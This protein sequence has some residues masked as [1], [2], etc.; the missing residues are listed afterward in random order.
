[1]EQKDFTCVFGADVLLPNTD[2]YTSFAV[3]ACDQFTSNGEYWQE[4]ADLTKGKLTALDMILPEYYLNGDYSSRIQ[5]IN[6]NIKNYVNQAVVLKNSMVLTVRET[7]SGIKRTGLVLAVDLE[8]YNFI[9]GEKPLIRPTEATIQDRIPPRLKIRQDASAEFPHVMMFI[10]DEKRSIVEGLYANRSAL[11]KV[12][13]FNLNM[14]GG[15]LTGYRVTDIKKVQDGFNAL[16]ERD[17][18]INKYGEDV[19]FMMAVGDGN[20]S[21]ATAKAHWEN[22]KAQTGDLSHP[23]RYALCEVVNIYDEGII[24]EPIH[25]LIK[26]VN[27]EDFLS[28]YSKLDHGTE[29]VYCDKETAFGGSL[30]VPQAIA[31][32]DKY[33][34]DYIAKN[35]GEVDYIHGDDDVKALADGD[36]CAVAILF[37]SINKSDLFRDVVRGG[38]LPKKTFS[39][40]EAREKRYYLEGRKIIK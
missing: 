33:I 18:L 17:R 15:H 34:A 38:N 8:A 32:T 39:I 9:K 28:G 21:L 10:D 5:T 11:E 6:E 2:D 7:A 40:G 24:F 23:A 19:P 37:S 3:V 1:M 36:N 27:R 31:V 25:R 22:V 26:G 4:L 16:I 12:Y 13:D 35:G 30:S 14:D 20:H 29:R